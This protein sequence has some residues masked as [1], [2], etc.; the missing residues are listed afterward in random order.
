MAGAKV[1]DEVTEARR[2]LS[3]QLPS[4]P[5]NYDFTLSNATSGGD[6]TNFYH[7]AAGEELALIEKDSKDSDNKPAVIEDWINPNHSDSK[8]KKGK[9][10]KK[11]KNNHQIN[12]GTTANNHSSNG[13]SSNNSSSNNNNNKNEATSKSTK[14]SFSIAET[15]QILYS[16]NSQTIIDAT[17]RLSGYHSP[18]S[19]RRILGD[20][21]YIECLLPSQPTIHI[22]AFSLGFYVNKTNAMKFD[23][24]PSNVEPCYSHSLLDCLLQKSKMLRD[25][26]TSALINSQKRAEVLKMAS[27]SEDA[28]AQL[29]R[30]ATSTFWNN[31]SGTSLGSGVAVSAPNTFN[32]RLDGITLRPSWLVPLPM[33][34]KRRM[35]T[36]KNHSNMHKWSVAR[37]EEE[38][39]NMH[40]MDLRGGGIRD[41]NEE[42]QAA[43][44]MGVES[45]EERMD[46]AR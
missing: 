12:G 32:S 31:H 16:L 38:L 9:N 35:D 22:T 25:A 19:H 28:F 7:L 27:L 30:P 39:T 45:L 40:G 1:K 44:D 8:K 3:E 15:E 4:F 36:W 23:P 24:A 43:K 20:L 41:W 46:R 42:L 21:A 6:Y 11:K 10:Q 13:T 26:Y 34:G 17:I 14:L 29:Y 37:A 33:A 18:P 5:E 2:L